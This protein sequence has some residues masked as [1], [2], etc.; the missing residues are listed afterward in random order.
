MCA[1]L[2]GE[3]EAQRVGAAA[4]EVV[5]V[6]GDAVARAHHAGVEAAT[7]AVVVAHFDGAEQAGWVCR[8]IECWGEGEGGVAGRVAE[9][10]AVVHA[11][12]V[13]DAVGVE[14]RGWVE[15]VFDGFEGA[16]DAGAEH[17]LVEF[18]ADDAV[19][20]FAGVA[21]FVFADEGEA[22]L[23][24]GAHGGD[25]SGVF[26]VEDGADVEAADGGVGVPGSLGVV[27][28]EDVVEAFGV[29]GEVLQ[30]HGTVFDEGDRFSVAFHR[31]HDVEAGFA[32]FGDLGLEGGV[33]G[34]DDGLGV[35]EVGHECVEFGQLGQQRCVLVAVEFDDE[36]AVGVAF[37]HSVDGGAED[38]D[39]A[40][41][42]DHGAV[43]EFDGFGVKGD[44]VLAG[45][46][47][48]AEA[49]EL[50]DPQDFAGLDGVQLELDLGGEGE[51]AF[52]ADEEAG[53]VGTGEGFE[54]V[55]ADA[56][57]LLGEAGGDF[58]GFLFAEGAQAGD[59]LGGLVGAFAEAVAGAV[60]EDGG[61]GNDV[62]GHEAVA[63]GL[64]AAGV[65]GGHAA[66][67]AAAVGGGVD[68]EEQAMR[69]E[70]GVEVAED[71]A[72]F[73]DGAAAHRVDVDDT[74]EVL[75]AVDDEGVVDGLAALAGAAAAG[76]DGDAGFTGDGD[77]GG[78]V[79]NAFGDD[80]ADGHHLV[81]RGVGGVAAAVGGAE[82][83]GAA[84]VAAE[85]LG[86]GGVGDIGLDVHSAKAS[87][88]LQ[89]APTGAPSRP[90][91]IGPSQRVAGRGRGPVPAET[92]A[93][94]KVT[95]GCC[96]ID[97]DC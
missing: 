47:G 59:E 95:G 14:H 13:D 30:G 22:F 27:L 75:G 82:F 57:E 76:E 15:D 23:G 35:A 41:E 34:G 17:A 5:F 2:A 58:G 11:G 7:G 68:R 45:G 52:G 84:D 43:D 83:D 69:F 97:Y 53:E 48:G 61:D 39:L 73:D 3:G 42:V 46:H 50:A 4:G 87:L 36:Q 40:A 28:F 60:S 56:A 80:H 89:P 33:G 67:G 12:W 25:V 24:D 94:D 51:G 44:E 88:F 77:G 79:F 19:A 1:D 38:R 81:D 9:E 92:P 29:V 37:D 93:Q 70:G 21:A 54:V 65:V 26:H 72:G 64:A 20:V 86:E 49:G 31:H 6:A 91:T 10:G 8:P 96:L 78:D 90:L 18:G 16:D 85:A 55:A 66:D 32:D 62:V 71:D 74:A 63:D